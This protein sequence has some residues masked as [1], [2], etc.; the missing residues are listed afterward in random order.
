MAKAATQGTG[1]KGE[2]LH[3]I[4][5][6][7]FMTGAFLAVISAVIYLWV[8]P[9]REAA[10]NEQVTDYNQ[11]HG[12]LDPRRPTPASKE[13]YTS[14]ARFRDANKSLE[15]KTLREMVQDQLGNLTYTRFPQMVTKAQ[16]KSSTAEH[17]QAIELKEAP[18][19][20]ILA[21]AARVR[22]ANQS[23]QVAHINLQRR[24]KPA[25]MTAGGA[26]ASPLGGGAEDD[27]WGASLEFYTS[28]TTT[29]RPP[30]AKAA[31][32]VE[33]KAEENAEETPA[34]AE[35]PADEEKPAGEPV[36]ASVK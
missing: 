18:I 6:T 12:L 7:S 36:E 20:D 3:I 29:G 35:A 13:M 25:G 19:G 23:V 10:V 15:S 2:F 32:K 21:F 8:I 16:A 1:M 34:P 28:V 5:L 27:R 31:E 17:T 33:E 30:A 24:N 14:R 26:G 22:Q 4:I 9:G 11:L